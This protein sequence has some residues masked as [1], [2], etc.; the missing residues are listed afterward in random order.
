MSDLKLNLGSSIGLMAG[1]RASGIEDKEIIPCIGDSAF[2]HGGISPLVEI[3]QQATDGLIVVMDNDCNAATGHQPSASSG[4]TGSGWETKKANIAQIAKGCNIDFIRTTDPY[5]LHTT[6]A[7]FVEAL[8]KKNGQK[9]VVTNRECAYQ[10][11]T[12]RK[13]EQT[14]QARYY[15]KEDQCCSSKICVSEFGCPAIY[16][17][18]TG[19]AA[20]DDALCFGCGVCLEVCPSYA[21]RRAE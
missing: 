7:S 19:K 15:V 20:I 9:L 5:Q 21:F 4:V 16:L 12:R 6:Q 13:L 14:E 11:I 8:S 2:L 1:L 18:D 3:T 10:A 17:K